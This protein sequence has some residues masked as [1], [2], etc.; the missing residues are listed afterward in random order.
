MLLDYGV[1][2][3]IGVVAGILSALLGIGGGQVLVPC[4]LAALGTSLSG[5]MLM[6]TVLAT[7][8]A[9]IP[10]T[11]GWTAYQQSRAG[12]VDTAKV[13]R[14]ALGVVAGA[15]LGGFAAPWVPG[16]VLKAIFCV[17][18]FYV[19]LQMLAGR[20]PRF[21]SGWSSRSATIAGAATGA[22]S[23]WVGIGGGAVV[24][25]YL[26]AVGEPVARAT[27]ISSAVG[28]VVAASA[29]LG[30]AWSALAQSVS[31]PH[32]LG[33]VHLPAAAGVVGGSFF[34]V[35]IGMRLARAVPTLWVKRLFAVTLLAAGV[36]MALSLVG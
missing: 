21:E 10:F 1:F 14:L 15:L 17:F 36:K 6:K 34:G 27:G 28:V 30:Y 33:F 19:S 2:A 20:H 35:L 9:T 8:L 24:V 7:S 5:D 16:D 13:G 22:L 32:Q 26:L 3:G 31:L 25:P 29:T 11:G 23:S 4:L 12:N 18:A